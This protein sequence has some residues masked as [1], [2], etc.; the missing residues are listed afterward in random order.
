MAVEDGGRER[1]HKGVWGVGRGD[2][3]DSDG[4]TP[5]HLLVVLL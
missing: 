5:Q 3:I 4:L 2:S 1:D